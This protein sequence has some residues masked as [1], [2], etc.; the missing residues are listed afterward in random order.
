MGICCAVVRSWLRRCLV[1]VVTSRTTSRTRSSMR[2]RDSFHA[3][4]DKNMVLCGKREMLSVR[5]ERIRDGLYRLLVR[6]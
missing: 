2:N 6:T 1:S 5:S 4:R 3:K